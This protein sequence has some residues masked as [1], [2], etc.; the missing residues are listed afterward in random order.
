MRADSFGGRLIGAL[1][2]RRPEEQISFKREMGNGKPLGRI[3]GALARRRDE[4]QKSDRLPPTFTMPSPR[5]PNA[6][7]GTW[8]PTVGVPPESP[9]PAL[10]SAESAQ[11]SSRSTSSEQ[12]QRDYNSAH[13][14]I[15]ART[16]FLDFLEQEYALVVRFLMRMGASLQGAEEAAQ[17]AFADAWVSV[18]Q[19]QWA[20]VGRPR[21]WIR[22][23]ALQKYEA[24]ANHPQDRRGSV[25]PVPGGEGGS[26]EPLSMEAS[27]VLNAVNELPVQPRLLMSFHLDGF[28]VSEISEDLGIP[29]TEVASGI[30][31]ARRQL[32]RALA[33]IK[34]K[35]TRI[36]KTGVA[37]QSDDRDLT[38]TDLEVED[39]LRFA[40]EL[41]ALQ[42]S[43]MASLADSI[44]ARV[45]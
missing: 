4:G 12:Q 13:G 6:E 2:R 3:V 20:Q 39:S 14:S 44:L 15:V 19:G 33:G 43:S 22:L 38:I 5:L 25:G 42:G 16:N 18:N 37:L 17:A 8:A 23:R 32:A 36:S 9:E 29:E 7:R 27:F 21:A 24:K 40:E 34:P 26:A 41:A 45:G 28:N 30:E 11:E 35:Q 31:G 10:D 1:A